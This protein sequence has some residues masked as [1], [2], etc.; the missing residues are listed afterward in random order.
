MSAF[1]RLSGALQHQIVSRLGFHSLRPVQE[2]AIDAILAGDNCVVLAPT[3]GGKTEAAFFPVLSLM[4]EQDWRPISCLYLSPIRALLNNQEDRLAR[5]ADLI[6]RRVFKWHGDV[7]SSARTKF[8]REPAD[9]VLTTPESLEAML[10]SS[11]FPARELF[12][13]LR[14]VVIDEIHAFADDDRG[15]HLACVL[16]RLTRYARY[17]IQRIGLSAT[18]GNP[19]EILRWVAGS[20]KRP[21]RVVDPG[22]AKKV[23]EISLDFVGSLENAA[24]VIKELHPG[25][26]RLAFVDARRQAEQLGQLLND[27]KVRTFVTHGSLSVEERQRAEEAFASGKDCVI[28]ATSALELGIDVGDL[29]HVLQIDSPP[30]VASFLQRMGRTGRREGT[31]PNCTFLATKD[32]GLL[33]AAALIRLHRQGFVEPVRPSRRASHILAHQLMALCV[34]LGGVEPGDWWSWLEGATSLADLTP[35]ERQSLVAHMQREDILRV[36]DAKLWLGDEGEKKYGRA[37]FRQLYAV[38]DAPKLV[39]VSWNTREIGTVDAK[40]LA[41]IDSDEERGSFILAGK[42][43]QIAMVDWERGRCEV[44]PAPAGKSTRWSGGSRFLS[45]ELCQSMREVLVGEDVDPA[46]S[47]RAQSRLAFMRAEHDFLADERAPLLDKGNDVEW[48]TF[49]GGAANT[50]L[51]K[52][53]EAELGGRVAAQNT[54]LT[55]KEG[56]AKSTQA[57]R[58]KIAG[59]RAAGRPTSSDALAFAQAAQRTPVSK[60]QPCLPE[61]LLAD[62]LAEK[63][64]DVEGARRVIARDGPLQKRDTSPPRSPD[65]WGDIQLLALSIDGYESAGSFEACA[66]IA[67]GISAR[68]AREGVAALAAAETDDLRYTLFFTARSWRHQGDFPDAESMRFIHALVEELGRRKG[69]DWL[70][71]QVDLAR[72]RLRTVNA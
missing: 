13:N 16:E 58:E 26:K 29:D 60:F 50:L 24:R 61:P 21:G 62:L 72:E 69:V 38:F 20:S 22:G 34:Q 46:W 45:Y 23:P 47:R 44:R 51:A 11:R 31:S 1:D 65:S 17:D 27:E 18:V 43:W 12:A 9:L 32:S 52:V 64:L 70:W 67:N 28:V 15:A 66:A 71:D 10:M 7:S 55:F 30:T 59:L 53:L 57:I 35:D 54:R 48:W 8:L 4:D 3:A 6:G 25:K 5:Y 37:N 36:T 19:E 49:A 33:Q 40:F 63:L 2:Q 56:A 39:V 68:Y 41:T 14:A 42:A